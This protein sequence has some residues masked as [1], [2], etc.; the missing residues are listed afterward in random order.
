ML[1][2]YTI[3]G[4]VL[5]TALPWSLVTFAQTYSAEAAEKTATPLVLQPVDGE[6]RMR[7]PP[8]T[9]LSTLAAHSSSK[10]MSRTEVRRIS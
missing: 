6:Q 5:F 8:P 10:W 7:R 3:A 1:R 4:S 9:T 2:G